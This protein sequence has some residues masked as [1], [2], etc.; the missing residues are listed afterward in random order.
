MSLID[1][2][3]ERSGRE[4]VLLGLLAGVLAPLALV[5]GVLLPLA[6]HRT[7][8]ERALAEEEKLNIWVAAQAAEAAKL[9]PAEPGAAAEV[10][11]PI[12]LSALEQGLKRAKLWPYVKRLEAQAQG[13][14]ALDFEEVEFTDLMNWLEASHPRWG[15]GFDSFR[16]EPRGA[17][18]MVK[19]SMVLVDAE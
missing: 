15:Y 5:F 19:V 1:W 14:V 2:L 13:G 6:E 16:I 11:E 8:A 18:A 10:P 17:A 7:A 4:R 3:S 12:G 9:A